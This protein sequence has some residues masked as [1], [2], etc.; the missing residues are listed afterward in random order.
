MTAADPLEV[1]SQ[2]AAKHIAYLR[3]NGV[4]M[5]D[6]AAVIGITSAMVGDGGWDGVMWAY[7]RAWHELNQGVA[8]PGEKV[9]AKN[10]NAASVSALAAAVG[11]TGGSM[12]KADAPA[13]KPW[14]D[15]RIAELRPNFKGTAILPVA[16]RPEMLPTGPKQRRHLPPPSDGFGRTAPVF[17]SV[18]IA[19]WSAD[20]LSPAMKPTASSPHHNW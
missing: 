7:A 6:A 5:I 12:V 10:S 16:H 18:L 19:H 15:F 9:N 1:A 11:P 4:S 20:T 14:K 13:L 8:V 3:R 2:V 17:Q